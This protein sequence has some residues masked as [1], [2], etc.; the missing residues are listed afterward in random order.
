MVMTESERSFSLDR[1][2]SLS[3]SEMRTFADQL[4]PVTRLSS[5][6]LLARFAMRPWELA[7]VLSR[8]IVI[9]NDPSYRERLSGL[10]A[11]LEG[12]TAQISLGLMEDMINFFQVE[13]LFAP[14]EIQDDPGCRA[15][16]VVQVLLEGG[17]AVRGRR[18]LAEMLLC[19]A[20]Q[21]GVFP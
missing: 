17:D 5:V 21:C 12:A 15:R 3:E 1:V 6:E 19:R 10:R 9:P 4:L 18:L 20:K 14:F 13:G 11:R 8:G 16:T 2:P 7:A